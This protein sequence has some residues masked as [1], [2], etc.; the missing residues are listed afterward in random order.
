MEWVV[1]ATPRPLYPRGKTR[2]PL[3]RRMGKPQ[4]RSGRMR[5]ISSPSGFDPWTVQPVASRY[6]DWAFAVHG[7]VLIILILYELYLYTHPWRW[8]TQECSEKSTHENQTPGNH[9]KKDKIFT[10][11]RKFEIRNKWFIYEIWNRHFVT[12]LT[13]RIRVFCEKLTVAKLLKAFHIFCVSWRHVFPFLYQAAFSP[14]PEL[15]GS[16]QHT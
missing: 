5:N 12:I 6:T 15:N 11:R 3:H 8:K 7:V 2:Y 16:S 4:G 14:F 13:P 9:P 10:K 1:N